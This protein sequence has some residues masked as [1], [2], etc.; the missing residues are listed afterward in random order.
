[1]T[2]A[3]LLPILHA[4]VAGCLAQLRVGSHTI[5]RSVIVIHLIQLALRHLLPLLLMLNGNHI[6]C[7]LVDI[8]R[9][10]VGAVDWPALNIEVSHLPIHA[11]AIG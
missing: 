8:I 2:G 1:M 3:W 7:R 10:A 11:F 5:L 6:G 9:Q 4:K